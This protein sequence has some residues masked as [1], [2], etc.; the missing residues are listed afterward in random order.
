MKT[1]VVCLLVA[2]LP[3]TANANDHKWL[4]RMTAAASCALSAYDAI[5]TSH[6]VGTQGITERNPVG[7][8]PAL[9]NIKAG[10]CVIP[11][12]VGETSKSPIMKN[13][14]MGI[15]I[16]SAVMFG[17]TIYHNQGVI[18]ATKYVEVK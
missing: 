4:R 5:Q 17:T 18:N 12:V 1:P 16:G 11:I 14:M 13:S 2:L 9:W 7:S 6:Y 15:S 8:G 10:T 3:I